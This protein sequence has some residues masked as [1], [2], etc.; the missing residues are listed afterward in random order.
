MSAASHDIWLAALN[1]YNGPNIVLQNPMS[2]ASH[3]QEGQ[4]AMEGGRHLWNTPQLW[5]QPHPWH[6]SIEQHFL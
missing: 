5:I 4:V 3:R 2:F 1:H 6:C